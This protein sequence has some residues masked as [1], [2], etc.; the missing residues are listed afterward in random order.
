MNPALRIRVGGSVRRLRLSVDYDAGD[1]ARAIRLGQEALPIARELE[2][3]VSR[4]AERG[5]AASS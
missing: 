1:E 4:E 3:I 5:S 2:K